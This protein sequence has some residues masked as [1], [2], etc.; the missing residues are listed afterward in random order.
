LAGRALSV[1]LWPCLLGDALKAALAM[2]AL[3]AAWRF[4]G[5]R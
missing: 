4:A 2:G 3:P 5:R 1:G